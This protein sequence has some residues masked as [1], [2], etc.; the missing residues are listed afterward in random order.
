MPPKQ[1]AAERQAQLD[2]ERDRKA[3]AEKAML[4]YSTRCGE[5]RR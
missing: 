4:T 5:H 3:Q 2:I 1:K